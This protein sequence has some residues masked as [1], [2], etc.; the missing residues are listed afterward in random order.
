MIHLC[1]ACDRTPTAHPL[2]C[3]APR[4]TPPSSPSTRLPAAPLSTRTTS[5][6]P[7]NHI[8]VVQAADARI[9]VGLQHAEEW[10]HLLHSSNITSKHTSTTLSS[11]TAALLLMLFVKSNQVQPFCTPIAMTDTFSASF[12]PGRTWSEKLLGACC[13]NFAARNAIK[14]S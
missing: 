7:L 3:M 12:L 14:C 11:T 6:R 8:P 4:S 13:L 1:Y 2:F 10:Y 9:K 5:V